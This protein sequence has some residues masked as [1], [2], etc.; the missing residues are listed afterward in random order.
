M[1]LKVEKDLVVDP[2]G[3]GPPLPSIN[4]LVP[5]GFF[6]AS[7]SPFSFFSSLRMI[8]SDLKMYYI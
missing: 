2:V 3:V 8:S 4:I 7:P 6:K 5:F 1:S